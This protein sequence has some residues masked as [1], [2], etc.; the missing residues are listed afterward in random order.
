M[1]TGRRQKLVDI[2][3]SGREGE[4]VYYMRGR[5]Q[6]RRRYVVPRDPRTAKQLVAREKLGAAAKEW[7]HSPAMT[8]GERAAC[9][10][11]GGKVKSR[12]RLGQWGWLTGQQYFVAVRCRADDGRVERE[13][14]RGGNPNAEG[15]GPK[16]GRIPN[17][18]EKRRRGSWGMVALGRG[19]RRR[20]TWE[21]CRSGW[22][23][24]PWQGRMGKKGTMMN[25]ECGRQGQGPLTA[26]SGP[27][28][29]GRQKTADRRR[30][31]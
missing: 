1:R 17:C 23:A 14:R 6:C 21:W 30:G 7:S 15:R 22:L 4:W 20:S 12:T 27:W 3:K 9:R 24:V 25:V 2:P 18:A 29:T 19:R 13:E 10:T 11:A 8:E 5:T 31:G 16:E 26:D 28:T